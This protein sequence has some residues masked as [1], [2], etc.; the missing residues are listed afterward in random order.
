MSA[1]GSFLTRF[2]LIMRRDSCLLF[3]ELR[4]EL[5]RLFDGNGNEFVVQ[6]Y[7]DTAWNWYSSRENEVA[8]RY[9]ETKE[10]LRMSLCQ[11]SWLDFIILSI[12]RYRIVCLRDGILASLTISNA[13][14]SRMR[15]IVRTR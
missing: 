14:R 4:L 2:R 1:R 15:S 6:S 12:C 11:Q 13:M 7:Q 5:E 3:D 10:R 9:G 8:R